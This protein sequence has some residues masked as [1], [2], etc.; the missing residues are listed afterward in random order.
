LYFLAIDF[1]KKQD[2]FQGTF[3]EL[4][5]KKRSI[6][7]ASNANLETFDKK[8]SFDMNQYETYEANVLNFA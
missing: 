8:S 7:L 6:K 4:L 3:L 5:E 2:F 1:V